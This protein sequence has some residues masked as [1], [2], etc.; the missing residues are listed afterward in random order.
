MQ[1][2][3]IASSLGQSATLK[4]N[5]LA[6]TLK[7]Q[8]KDIIHLGGGEPEF[9]IPEKAA[10]ESLKKI[11]SKRVIYTPTGGVSELKEK[12]CQYT[13]ENYGVKVSP[14]NIV[15]SSGAKQAI[16]N[17]LLCAVNPGDEVVFPA[18][19][20]VSYTEM[21]KLVYGQP[22]PVKPSK[23]LL[24]SFEEIE[25]HITSNTKAIMLNT[26]NNPSGLIYGAEF[27]EKIVA[28]CEERNIFLLMDD[29]YNKLVFDGFS[30]PSAFSFSK[31]S[32][33][34][35]NIVSVNGVSKTFSMTGFRIGWS[36][37]SKTMA[38]AMTKVQGQ[39][40]SCP[41]DLS[42]A[43]SVGALTEG[44]AFTKRMIKDL[45]DKRNALV[46]ELLKI[47]KIKLEKPQGT[48]YSFADFSAYN[49]NSSQLSS[50]LIEKIGVVTVPGSEFGMEGHLRISFC[51]KKEDIIRGV[52]KI[53]EYL[54]GN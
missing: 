8:G 32:I 26:P 23:G 16:Y 1:I 43:A 4:L 38:S 35:S 12:I 5:E 6:S 11:N 44:D 10:Q 39:I 52:K 36:V 17:F 40:T 53:R 45:E 21:V 9:D 51:G 3:K 15:V 7:K 48:F 14:A 24:C 2:S 22:I 46:D 34:E 29:I 28:L 42:Q 27:I 54:D 18:P 49:K 37:S 47:K 20:W 19:Y 31:K 50:E 13:F 41:S 30:V 25:S 33:D